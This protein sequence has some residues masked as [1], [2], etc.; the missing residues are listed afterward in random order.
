VSFSRGGATILVAEDDAAYGEALSDLLRREGHAVDHV[1]DGQDA[2]DVLRRMGERIDLVLCDLLLPRRTGFDVVKEINDLGLGV[3]VLAMTGVYDNVR[4]V[5]SLRSLGVA[6][7]L[8]KSAPFEH[9]L[10][11]VN[12]LIFPCRDNQRGD[13]RVAVA[14]PAQFRLGGRVCYG[15]TY[16]L[17]VSG[18]YVRTPE[19]PLPGQTVELALALPTARQMV[20]LRAE[21]MHSASPR[22]VKGTAYPAGFG[23][24]FLEPSPLARAAIRNFV[25]VV[26]REETEGENL[27]K[28]V[29]EVVD[30]D[31]LV[32]A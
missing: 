14:V 17:S 1:L 6:G 8:H 20:G 25:E 4:E 15:T 27:G 32:S 24:R 31:S 9:L 30:A 26:H 11:R 19:T 12:N 21:V 23:A 29:F 28:P 3:P 22:E 16:N 7:Y 13:Y 2:I 18:L 10:F 5:H